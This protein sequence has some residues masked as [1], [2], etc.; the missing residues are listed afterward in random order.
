M[1]KIITICAALLMT[2]SVFAQSPEK[3]SY[4]AVV[5]DGSNNLVSST[6]VGMQISI[7]QGSSSGTAV[8][9][10]T[11]TPTSNANGLVSLEIGAGTV[12]SGDFTTIDWANGPYFIK[13][14]TDPTGGT[15]YTITGTSQ[16]L[17]VP[18]ALHA[19]TAESISATGGGSSNDFYLGQD[20]LGGI[21]Y[22]IY[23]DATGTQHGLIVN[24]TESTAQWQAS[25]TLTNANRTEDGAYNTSLMTSSAAAT[26]VTGLGAGWYL[27]SID[28][29][30]LLYYN[31]F[32]TNKA[33][34]TG[35]FTL[36]SA[37]VYWS[38]T[39]YNTTSAYTF[40]ANGGYA[41]YLSKNNT[42]TVR[43]VRAF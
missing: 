7:L 42:F 41:E 21:V 4:Q 29:L 5:R 1:K 30:E 31:R 18:Y 12:I 11:Q 2:A 34:R 3:M 14:E 28:E 32:T 27:P 24:K 39:E 10:E 6:A 36:L 20:T 17:S 19:K 43:A 16:L 26:Y 40:G 22:Y 8:Y 15:S 25:G 23:K 9:V 33:L 37:A 38:S 35:G 13:T